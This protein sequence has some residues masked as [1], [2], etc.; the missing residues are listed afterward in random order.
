MIYKLYRQSG[1]AFSYRRYLFILTV[2]PAAAGAAAG[3][4]ALFLLGPVAAVAIGA[5]AALLTFAGVLLYPVYLITARRSHF[6]NNFVYTLGVMLP[7][8]AAG[9]PLGRVVTRLAEVEEDRFIARELALAAREM[10]VMGSSPEE[11]L[12]H[13]A[14][15]VPSPS[16]RE[17]VELITK[18]SRVT[19][20][21]DLVLM[22]RLDWML[23]AKQVKAQ[24][25]VRSLSLMFEIFVVVV[26]LLPLLVYIVALAF[27]PLGALQAGPMSVDPLTLM[28]FM[29][30]IY[31]PIVGFIFYVIF[32][33]MANI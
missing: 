33:S 8:L 9:L 26:M 24:S 10:V 23:R 27:S 16:Y 32:D 17:T 25:L 15:R 1:L 30:L 18:S 31:I 4:G 28:L 3:I 2:A 11:A 12:A 22:A 21:V 13:S 14:E 20:R 29:A 19:Q 5:V 7:L 6:E